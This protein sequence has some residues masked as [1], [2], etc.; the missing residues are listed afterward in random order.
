MHRVDTDERDSS[1]NEGSDRGGYLHS[2][3]QTA[4]NYAAVWLRG[5]KNICQRMTADNVY[6]S[7]PPNGGQGTGTLFA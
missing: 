7:C 5:C 4:R 1:Q 6:R 2:L 3:R